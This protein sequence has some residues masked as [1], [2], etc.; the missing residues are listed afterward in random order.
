MTLENIE[1]YIRELL[2]GAKNRLSPDTAI[3]PELAGM[4]MFGFV[5]IGAAK[6]DDPLFEE[7][8]NPGVIGPHFMAPREWL[9]EAAG[10]VSVFF[11]MTDRV[12]KSMDESS[13]WPSPELLHARIEGQAF[14]SW[15]MLSLADEIKRHGDAAMVPA[16]DERF[17]FT[18]EP[19]TSNWSERHVAFACGLGT[20]GLSRGI[21]TKA[22]TPGRFGS[23]VT[24]LDLQPT[25]R[26][27]R[28]PYEY[29][30]MCGKCAE[31][32][33]AGAITIEHG[34]NHS[35]CSA[36]IDRTRER[37]SPRYAC[38]RCQIGVPCMTGPM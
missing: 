9:P 33:P 18:K 11:R 5:A 27:Y 2:E 7:F 24:S 31:N 38:G 3:S 25:N 10:V 23:V 29:C 20:F 8:R 4:R 34:K 13:S 16:A 12:I 19:Y 1:G 35:K 17:S 30:A 32:C 26:E 21:I 22:G 15:A 14:I 36:F 28:E 6:A 37:F